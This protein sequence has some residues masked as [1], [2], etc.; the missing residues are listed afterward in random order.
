[1]LFVLVR[2]DEPGRVG[3]QGEDVFIS[4]EK[5]E[6]LRGEVGRG[7]WRRGGRVDGIWM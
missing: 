3:S 2:L 4:E 1:M 6:V 7:T 5:G